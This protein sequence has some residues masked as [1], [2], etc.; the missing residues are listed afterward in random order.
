MS[1]IVLDLKGERQMKRAHAVQQTKDQF[2]CYVL[3]KEEAHHIEDEFITSS[4]KLSY[5]SI[6]ISALISLAC[7]I[8]PLFVNIGME[9]RIL[10]L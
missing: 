5:L 2:N 1:I 6:G 8:V 7:G 4:S 3:T 9:I 10:I